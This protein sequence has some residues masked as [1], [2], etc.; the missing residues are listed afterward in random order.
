MGN[1]ML[2]RNPPPF[3]LISM[4]PRSLLAKAFIFA[5]VFSL[6][7]CGKKAVQTETAPPPEVLVTQVV[8]ADV[9]VVHEWVGTLNGSVNADIRAR[10]NGYLQKKDY[11]EGSF[12]KEGDLLFEIDPRPFEAALAGAKSDLLQE[13]AVQLATQAD[14]ERSQDLFNKK[15]ISVQEFENKKQLNQSHVAKVAAVEAGVQN[16][17]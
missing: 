1:H 16:T 6:L 11:Q 15:V 9:P 17:T 2:P 4:V 13:Q 12:V 5:A 7:G 8:K 14:F 3:L 10:V